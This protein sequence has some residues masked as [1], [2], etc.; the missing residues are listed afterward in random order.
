MS[1]TQRP[2]IAAM[3]AASFLFSA[4]LA[5]GAGHAAPQA[6]Q[7]KSNRFWWPDQLDLQKL[8]ANDPRSNPYGDDFDYA[9]AFR[10]VDLDALKRQAHEPGR[11]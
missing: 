2:F 11:C 4:P 8:R 1:R 10:Q 3:M 5:L 6:G 7:P 9:E